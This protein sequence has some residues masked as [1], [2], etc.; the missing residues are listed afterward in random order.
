VHSP[1]PQPAPLR[2]GQRAAKPNPAKGLPAN[3]LLI[4]VMREAVEYGRKCEAAMALL[5]THPQGLCR[6]IREAYGLGTRE[7]AR[8]LKVSPSY[9]SKLDRGYAALTWEL[10]ERLYEWANGGAP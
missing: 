8:R 1:A 10:V 2:P 9:L 7:F 5:R 6:E 4:G 3:D